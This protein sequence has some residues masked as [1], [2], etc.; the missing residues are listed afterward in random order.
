[1]SNIAPAHSFYGERDLHKTVA[2]PTTM[3]SQG[4]VPYA[5]KDLC[6]ANFGQCTAPRVKGG[7]LCVG[8]QRQLDKRNAAEA[9]KAASEDE[10]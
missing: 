4:G 1:M 8:H 10:S 7:E 2:P 9:E 6:A 5:G 3:L